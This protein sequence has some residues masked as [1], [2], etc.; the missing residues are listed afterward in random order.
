V[1]NSNVVDQMG[2]VETIK[3][4]VDPE[5]VAHTFNINKTMAIDVGLY[6]AIGFIIGFLLKR[7]SEYFISLV[8]LVLGLIVLQQ[9]DYISLV[10]NSAKIH[11]VL[12]LQE[13]PFG[14]NAWSS[15]LSEWIRSHMVSFLSLVVSFLIGLKVG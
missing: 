1:V 6:G 5:K 2:I 15:L 3:N 7:Y 4:S 9:F 12:G 10:V 8:L 13:M 14:S 11:E